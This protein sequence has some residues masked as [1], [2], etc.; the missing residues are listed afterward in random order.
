MNKIFVTGNLT[1]DPET[2]TTKDGVID[3]ATERR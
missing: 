3:M 1:R 2:G